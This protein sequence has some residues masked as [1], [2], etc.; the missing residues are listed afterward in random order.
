VLLVLAIAAPAFADW[1]NAQ[2]PPHSPGT[3]ESGAGKNPNEPIP[4]KDS[5]H[6]QGAPGPM[7]P[8]PE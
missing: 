2:H 4:P 8:G 6:S 7:G 5:Y 3:G 1:D